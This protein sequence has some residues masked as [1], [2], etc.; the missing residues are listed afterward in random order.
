MNNSQ[1]VSKIP[2]IA[3]MLLMI[4]ANALISLNMSL[5]GDIIY[6][7]GF[8]LIGIVISSWLSTFNGWIALAVSEILGVTASLLLAPTAFSVISSLSAL[9]YAITLRYV[10][11]G[12]LNRSSAIAISASLLTLSLCAY[13]SAY[14]FFSSGT[15][16][17][18][19]IISSFPS[20][21]NELTEIIC[22]ST[23]IKV[24]GEYVPSITPDGAIKYLNVIIGIIPALLFLIVSIVGYIGAWLFKKLINKVT[25][26]TPAESVWRL[27]TAFPT[28]VFF[29]LGLIV[30]SISSSVNP[31][32]LAAINVCIILFP[33]LFMTGLNS[34]FEPKIVNGYKLPR[35]LRPAILFLLILNNFFYFAAAC[36]LFAL[37]DSIRGIFP[38][39]K[40]DE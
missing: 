6:Y 35:I 20:F 18:S 22:T 2:R 5:C 7:L 14:T 26:L 10:I 39:R 13:F 9:P 27:T 38:K 1:N 36:A 24:A 25:G 23:H 3:L 15:L 29:I 19:S 12:K 17:P 11:K 4:I 33:V 21:F 34:A 31:F 30:T 8:L 28:S 32:S 16:D 37:Y 40:T